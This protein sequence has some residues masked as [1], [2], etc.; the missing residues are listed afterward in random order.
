LLD[1]GHGVFPDDCE[2]VESVLMHGNLHLF[3]C[4]EIGIVWHDLTQI[5]KWCDAAQNPR[6]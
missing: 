1:S 5:K 4:N 3:N 2:W 6:H